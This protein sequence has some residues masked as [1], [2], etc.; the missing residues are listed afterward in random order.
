MKKKKGYL[1]I[2]NDDYFKEVNHLY[3][4]SKLNTEDI[5]DFVVKKNK[6][7]KDKI[8]KLLVNIYP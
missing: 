8:K 1:Q 7:V 3:V 5:G 4:G 2:M 6:T